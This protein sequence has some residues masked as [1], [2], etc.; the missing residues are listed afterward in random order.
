MADKLINEFTV[1]RPI[2]EAW[3][4]ITDVEKIAPCLPGAELREIEGD[5]Y[6]G[7]V[8][9][10]LGPIATEFEGEARIVEQDDERH[11]AVVEA[12]GRDKKGRGNA[13]ADIIAEAESLSPTSTRCVVTWTLHMSGKVS[14]F[15]RIGVLED[16][17]GKLMADFAHNL[18]EMLD[19][20]DLEPEQPSDA[21]PDATI[22]E[23][24]A[25][26]TASPGAAPSDATDGG[27]PKVRVIGGPAAEPIDLMELG[28][29]SVAKRVV[30]ALLALLLVV[31]LLRR[32][33]S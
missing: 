4:I 16:V 22:D 18:N 13:K 5:E 24:T 28:G 8:K 10:K 2:E 23:A 27:A 20:E 33:R 31:L 32:R 26:A 17:S 30:P 6:R 14:Q 12:A 25:D 1:N 7:I 3:P 19:V 11:R 15:G 9:V 29:S 21:P